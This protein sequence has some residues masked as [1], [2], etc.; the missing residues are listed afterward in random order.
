MLIIILINIAP[1]HFDSPINVVSGFRIV[2]KSLCISLLI[3]GRAGPTR[4]SRFSGIKGELCYVIKLYCI[5]IGEVACA[6]YVYLIKSRASC[7]VQG[8]LLYK[9][10]FDD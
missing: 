10:L 2:Y 7:A 8:S 6:S 9:G 3:P 1:W 5:E 4:R